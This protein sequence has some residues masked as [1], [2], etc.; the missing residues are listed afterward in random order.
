MNTKN[1][2][3]D[4]IQ[5]LR[6]IAAVLVVLTHARYTLLNTDQWPLANQLFF[7][8]AMGVDL[9]FIISGF[10][11][12]YSTSGSDGSPAYVANFVVKRFAR[13]WPVYAVV[14]VLYGMLTHGGL[15]YFH[16]APNM[17]VLWRS[18]L[19][20]PVDTQAPPYFGLT[21]PLGWT[22]EFEMYFYAI[23][24][25]SLLFKRLRWVVLASWILLSVVLLPLGQRG[26]AMDVTANLGYS[27]SYLSIVTNAFVLEFLAG[28]AICLLYQSPWIVIPNRA[29][30]YHLIWLSTSF[31]AWSIFSGYGGMHGPGKWGLPLML[32]VLVLAIASKTVEIVI[33]RVLMWLGSISFSLYM[34]HLI[35]QFYV[36]RWMLRFDAEPYI[37]SWGF[38]FVSTA[39]AISLAALSHRYLEQGLSNLVRDALLG[40]LRRRRAGAALAP[41]DTVLG[42]DRVVRVAASPSGL[43][44]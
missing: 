40:I 4:W 17:S 24:A 20:L 41:A 18:L 7:P 5:L 16:F 27:V 8:T 10:I 2:N 3:L 37:H 14:T 30:A 32:M 13:V 11:M 43:I 6:G 44:F 9:F 28:A 42:A 29:L 1:K 34:T 36:T 15:H 12:C 26:F 35:A 19:L 31:A 38:M 23:F 25:V 39:L 33:P 21:L 22:L